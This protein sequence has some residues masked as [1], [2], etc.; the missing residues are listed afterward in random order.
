MFYRL[1][2][3]ENCRM[4]AYVKP[5]RTERQLK[6]LLGSTAGRLAA[7]VAD[8]LLRISSQTGKGFSSTGF[9]FAHR[10]FWCRV[11]RA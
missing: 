11:F 9:Q 6:R 3:E 7:L 1:G 8:P 10:C 2:L 4:Q 5:L